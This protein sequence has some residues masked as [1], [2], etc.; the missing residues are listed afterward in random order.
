[1]EQFIDEAIASKPE[2][3]EQFINEAI[4][5][6]PELF[7]YYQNHT[8]EVHSILSKLV[9]FIPPKKEEIKDIIILLKTIDEDILKE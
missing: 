4:M 5:G 1:M 6:D 2:L 7:S 3:M 9:A 8:D